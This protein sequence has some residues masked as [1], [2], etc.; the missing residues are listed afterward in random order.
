MKICEWCMNEIDSDDE[1]FVELGKNEIPA[2]YQNQAK[3]L[4]VN[5][6]PD[7]VRQR[8][9]GLILDANRSEI[10]LMSKLI[11]K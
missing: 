5:N 9:S 8:I 10:D 4:R 2:E 3:A 11:N 1:D 6:C 7:C